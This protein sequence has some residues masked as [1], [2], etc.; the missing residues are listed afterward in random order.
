MWTWD[1]A[2]RRSNL[3][4]HGADFADA[5]L[6]DWSSATTEPDLRRDY[7]E[8]RFRSVGFIGERLFVLIYAARGDGQRVISLRKAN[9]REIDKWLT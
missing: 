3:A 5:T 2:K 4:K 1:E 7:G 8:E 9:F 6:F